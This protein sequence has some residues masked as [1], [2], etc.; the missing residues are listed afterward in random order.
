MLWAESPPPPTPPWKWQATQ[1]LALNT[2]P[3]PSPWASGS[4]GCQSCSNSS[5]PA[6][7]VAGAR[8]R[9][10][11]WIWGR[12]SPRPVVSSQR[13]APRGGPPRDAQPPTR[14][15]EDESR[16]HHPAPLPQS[17]E[18]GELPKAPPPST[19]APAGVGTLR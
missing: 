19:T 14:Q 18:R 8:G 15:D 10:D 7:R 5:R 6:C 1:D 2:G 13:L 3:K 16:P 4:L 9:R 11:T 12:V 17:R